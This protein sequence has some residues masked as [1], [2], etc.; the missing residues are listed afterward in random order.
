MNNIHLLLS[1]V[2]S[3]NLRQGV[4]VS[5]WDNGTGFY[6]AVLKWYITLDMTPQEVHDLGKQEIQRIQEK[7]IAVSNH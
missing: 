1:K 4:G 3:Q 2:Y 6:E 7:M 5:N